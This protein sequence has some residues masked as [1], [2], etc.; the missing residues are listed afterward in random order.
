MD[1]ITAALRYRRLF[2]K[3]NYRLPKSIG[4]VAQDIVSPSID[5]LS[6]NMKDGGNSD[7]PQYPKPV[8]QKLE[9]KDKELEAILNK[10][11]LE[12]LGA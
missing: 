5:L 6:D 7:Y 11:R 8:I 12:D 1:A 10:I 9:S 3:Y 2:L 4:R